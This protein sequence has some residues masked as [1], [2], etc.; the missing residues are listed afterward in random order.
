MRFRISGI[1]SAAL[2]SM[3]LGLSAQVPPQGLSMTVSEAP[4]PLSEQGLRNLVAFSRALGYIRFFHPSDGAA[5]A[6]WDALAIQGMRDTE[7]ARNA[8]E[9]ADRLQRFFGSCAPTALFLAPGQTVPKAVQPKGATQLVR[10]RHSG[11]GLL[12]PNPLFRSEREYLPI[13]MGSAWWG[14]P[15]GEW[16]WDLGGEVKLSM[17]PVLFADAEKATL[18]RSVAPVLSMGGNLSS[19]ARS[20][21]LADVALAWGVFQHFYP[22]FDAVHVDWDAELSKALKAAAVDADAQAFRHTLQRMLATLQDGHIRVFTPED[23][24]AFPALKLQWVD[25][26]PCIAAVGEDVQG[27]PRGSRVVRVEGESIETWINGQQ[28]EI[29]SATEGWR[30]VRLIEM[31]LCGPE[32]SSLRLGIRTPKGE[33]REVV[34]SRK[35]TPMPLYLLGR[36]QNFSELKPGCWYVDLSRT[37]AK[38]FEEMLP[39]LAGAKGVLFDLRG[40]PNP[41]LGE[42]FLRHLTDQPLESA[43]FEVPLI[44]LPDGLGSRVWP[45]GVG[46]SGWEVSSWHLEP[47]APRIRG[48]AAFLIGPEA[49]SASESLLGIVEAYRLG[50]LIGQ[51]TAGTN[52]NTNRLSLPGGYRVPWTGMRVRKHD[53]SRHHGMGIHPTVQVEPTAQALAEGRDEV[54]EKGMEVLAR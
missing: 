25:G 7:G 46:G 31:M 22:Y 54:L 5:R 6:D 48:R 11:C 44:P 15:Q 34:L 4:R 12:F 45:G 32:G 51:T 19:D 43:H 49:V 18:P 9:L 8:V 53:G 10:W 14:D 36:P 3:A 38:A 39:K 35:V 13:Q 52:G 2:L 27:V 29:A 28:V 16:L 40:Y 50:D 33:A 1:T 47:A 26:G 23:A 17:A 37:D 20:V 30:H 42:S 21:R 24:E 41:M